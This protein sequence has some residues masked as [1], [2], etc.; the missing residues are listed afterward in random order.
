MRKVI[1][2]V[3]SVIEASNQRGITLTSTSARFAKYV[4]L[5]TPELILIIQDVRPGTSCHSKG[6]P[7]PSRNPNCLDWLRRI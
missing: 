5:F 1:S 2:S 6:R 4:Q 3:E 7:G